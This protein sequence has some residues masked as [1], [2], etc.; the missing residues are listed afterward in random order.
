[1]QEGDGNINRVEDNDTL[2]EFEAILTKT[3]SKEIKSDS[4]SPNS[5][6]YLNYEGKLGLA[7]IMEGLDH[8][9][10]PRNLMRKRKE[11]PL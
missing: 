6:L 5:N 7:T 3:I 10:V 8:P 1:M 9:K 4:L 2:M 11:I